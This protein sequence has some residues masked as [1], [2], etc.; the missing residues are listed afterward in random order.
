MYVYRYESRKKI[1]LHRVVAKA[2]DGDKV[3]HLDGDTMNNCRSN[4]RLTDTRGNA[5]NRSKLKIYRNGKVPTSPYKGVCWDRATGKWR[6]RIYLNGKQICL[7]RFMDQAKA[8][9]AYDAAA[10]AMFKVP[11]LNFSHPEPLPIS[12]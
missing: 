2:G 4:L 12:A 9:R 8:A 11:R 6:A 7:G 5:Q 1:Y 10:M 3:D